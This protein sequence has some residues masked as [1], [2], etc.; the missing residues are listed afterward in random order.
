[1]FTTVASSTTISWPKQTTP[2]ISQRRSDTSS[3]SARPAG[4]ATPGAAAPRSATRETAGRAASGA[5][6][7]LLGKEYPVGHRRTRPRPVTPSR[8]ARHRPNSL[9][10]VLILVIVFICI[11]PAV[12]ASSCAKPGL[13]EPD[14]AL[15]AVSPRDCARCAGRHRGGDRDGLL[16]DLG[17][18]QL[19]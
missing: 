1:M 5:S 19:G 11:K 17:G 8:L 9:T 13:E 18:H 3:A 4:P 15:S 10:A 7:C 14:H 12:P 6:G 2:R 16:V